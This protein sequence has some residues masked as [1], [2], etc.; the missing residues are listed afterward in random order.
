MFLLKGVGHVTI[1]VRSACNSVVL[2]MLMSYYSTLST[3]HVALA[4]TTC[5]YERFDGCTIICT[6]SNHRNQCSASPMF[7]W[8]EPVRT[9]SPF[10]NISRTE[11]W[12][13]RS[14]QAI[15]LNLGPNLAFRSVRFRFEPKSGTELYHHYSHEYVYLIENGQKTGGGLSFSFSF[16]TF[17]Q[18]ISVFSTLIILD[19]VLACVVFLS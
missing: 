8:F 2:S 9:R 11:N 3:V 17:K 12:T 18:N 10:H 13:Y 5:V 4:I 19:A 15:P 16:S 6:K 7:R 14:V 1:S